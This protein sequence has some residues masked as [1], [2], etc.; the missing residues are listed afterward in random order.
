MVNSWNHSQGKTK[1]G[2]IKWKKNVILRANFELKLIP[3]S[4]HIYICASKYPVG[5][6]SMPCVCV[7]VWTI[8]GLGPCARQDEKVQHPTTLIT[9]FSPV[10]YHLSFCI[11]LTSLAHSVSLFLPFSA[12]YFSPSLSISPP[13][14]LSVTSFLC[15]KS[16]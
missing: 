15:L 14:C 16:S 3:Q 8:L 12:F 10:L 2:D 1:H 11:L 6:C 5:N 9:L 4:S 13:F 7:C